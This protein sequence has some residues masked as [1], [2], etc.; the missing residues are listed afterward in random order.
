MCWNATV[1]MNTFIFVVFS[2]VVGLY[3]SA[4][5]IP[6]A[7]FFL[8]FGSMQLVEYFLWKFPYQNALFSVLGLCLIVLQ[9]LF[10]ILQLKTKEHLMPLLTV[11][12]GFFIWMVYVML[13]PTKYGIRFSST[14]APNGHLMWNWLPVQ[15]STFIIIYMLLMFIP[16]YLLGHTLK[17]I[18]GITTLI[19]SLITYGYYGTWGSVW[20]WL[21]SLYSFVV[22]GNSF[23]KSGYCA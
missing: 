15:L 4:L 12:L 16:L 23:M 17:I 14:V 6:E 7:A 20:C 2:I 8:S 21:A 9:P 1:S 5:N 18:G 3:N 10:S 11:Y 22:I 19:I 13:N